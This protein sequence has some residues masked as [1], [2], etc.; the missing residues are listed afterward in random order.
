MAGSSVAAGAPPITKK[1]ARAC[2]NARTA[3]AGG[4]NATGRAHRRK[5]C[6]DIALHQRQT[7]SASRSSAK[8]R[9]SLQS[10]GL[11]TR[12]GCA[13]ETLEERIRRAVREEIAVVLY[14]PRWPEMFRREKEHLL[15]CLP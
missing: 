7:G 11:A 15:S 13:M 6:I 5:P 4:G 10:G 14:D 8:W 2:S 3:A 1:A 12:R 9:R